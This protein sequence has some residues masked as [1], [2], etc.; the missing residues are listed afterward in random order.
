[1]IR[2]EWD[3]KVGVVVGYVYKSRSTYAIIAPEGSDKLQEVEL[4]K[5]IVYG[6]V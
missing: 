6:F 4:S 3:G 2:V 5:L 1:M